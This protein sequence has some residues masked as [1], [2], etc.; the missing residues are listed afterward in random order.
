MCAGITV[1][2][3]LVHWGAKEGGK[4][5]GIVGIGGLGTMGVKLAKAMGNKVVAISSSDSKREMA[6]EKGAEGYCNYNDEASMK[7][8]EGKIDLIL[9]TVAVNHQCSHQMKLLKKSGTIVL[10]GLVTEP[11]HIKALELIPTRKSVAGSYIGGIKATQDLLNFCAEHQIYPDC[12][13]VTADKI[14]ECW[15]TLLDNK[16]GS[17]R[18]IIDIEA[19]RKNQDFLPKD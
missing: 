5:I 15:Q 8:W 9:D 6:K 16:A 13:I 1:W 12:E 17:L 7:E 14:S 18:Y 19:S 11:M 4:V 10:L 2:D 3:P